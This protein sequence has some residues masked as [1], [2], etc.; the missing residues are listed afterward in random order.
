MQILVKIADFEA[1]LSEKTSLEKL[2][3][4]EQHLT[5]LNSQGIAKILE[6]EDL[7]EKCMH[8]VASLRAKIDAVLSPEIKYPIRSKLAELDEKLMT[9]PRLAILK[10]TKNNLLPQLEEQSE[11]ISEWAKLRE[12]CLCVAKKVEEEVANRSYKDYV[13][14]TNRGYIV[15]TVA[16]HRRRIQ[17]GPSMD[18]LKSISFWLTD[19]QKSARNILKEHTTPRSCPTTPQEEKSETP[20]RLAEN[21]A[22]SNSSQL[23]ENSKIVSYN[24]ELPANPAAADPLTLGVV[25]GALFVAGFLLHRYF[26]RF[27]KPRP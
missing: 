19:L 23:L 20:R 16:L 2:K 21:S 10:Y 27:R 12:D 18:V 4:S 11:M 24:P 6:W 3:R 9:K 14:S 5:L 13:D 7:Q 26:R 25:G 1:K 15:R 8:Q 22:G 17:K